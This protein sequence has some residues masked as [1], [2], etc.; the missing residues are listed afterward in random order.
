MSYSNLLKKTLI[1]L[2]YILLFLVAL[3]IT[4]TILGDFYSRKA[5]FKKILASKGY[6]IICLG[7]S[8]TYGFGVDILDTYPKQLESKLNAGGLGRHFDVFN[9]GIPGANSSQQLKYFQEILQ[10]HIKPELVILLAGANFSIT[11]F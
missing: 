1:C 6:T 8:F 5:P 11:T 10:R 3:E 9:L 7:D 2:F 4:L